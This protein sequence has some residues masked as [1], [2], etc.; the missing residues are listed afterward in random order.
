VGSWPIIIVLL[1]LGSVY[2]VFPFRWH[3][4]T[5]LCRGILAALVVK[6]VI[7][8]LVDG[9]EEVADD[10]ILHH[11]CLHCGYDLR[12]TPLRC[13]E[14]GEDILQALDELVPD[15]LIDSKEPPATIESR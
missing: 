7:E 11:K 15:G 13:P 14:C 3:I 8:R 5:W 10:R 9:S 2:E 1:A 6:V 12:A 4:S